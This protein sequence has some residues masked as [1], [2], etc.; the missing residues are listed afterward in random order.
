[1]VVKGFRWMRFRGGGDGREEDG[2]SFKDDDGDDDD[3]SADGSEVL[4]DGK[5]VA[6]SKDSIER[7]TRSIATLDVTSVLPRLSAIPSHGMRSGPDGSRFASQAATDA[8]FESAK[9][10]SSEGVD[11]L[12]ICSSDG[13]AHVLV[14]DMV[15]IGSCDIV[16]VP[17][18]QASH[19]NSEAHAILSQTADQELHL[20]TITL[21]LDTLGDP[22]LHVIAT[23]TKRIQNLLSYITQ[24]IHCITHDYTTGLQF[25]SR[26]IA[27]MQTELEEKQEGDLITNLYHLALTGTFSDT[28]KEWLVDI[29]KETNHKRWDQAVN[30][31][32]TNIQQHLFVH[33]KPALDRLSV[34]TTT[35]RGYARYLEESSAFEVPS[36]LFTK[37]LDGIDSLRVVSQKLLL[38]VMEEQRQFKAFSKWLRVMIDIGVAGPG[39]KGGVETEA[40]ENPNLEFPLLLKYVEHTML[41]SRLARFVEEKGA[42]HALASPE[43]SEMSYER[44]CEAVGKVDRLAENDDGLRVKDIQDAEALVNLPALTAYLS[45]N[46][47]V[48]L[49]RVTEWQSKMLAP[50]TSL[51]VPTDPETQILDMQVDVLPH[52]D[53][54]Q[55]PNAVTRLLLLPAETRQHLLLYSFF[56]DPYTPDDNATEHQPTTYHHRLEILD[57]KFHSPATILILGRLVDSEGA[58]RHLV[59]EVRVSADGTVSP[60]PSLHD[61]STHPGFVPE[62]LMV[63]G[64]EGKR[65]CLVLGNGGR[66]WVALDLESLGRDAGAAG[67]AEEEEEWMDYEEGVD[68]QM[69]G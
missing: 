22:L 32:Y 25:P 2:G 31:M 15:K 64:R 10:E 4:S 16:G 57:A 3:L 44:T 45:G 19:T 40:K 17:L 20:N 5:R 26:L 48:A 30:T 29:V 41:R 51:H 23:N 60:G 49:E 11:A 42:A 28:M 18:L 24:T 46:V 9:E 61:M 13:R 36:E 43:L 63:G 67:G 68:E 69:V 8:V 33:L 65:V 27:N 6:D 50:P 7:L 47:R 14:D 39:S 21:P 56:P 34:A 38:V 52:A 1:M 54:R 66:M 58:P 55:Q 12:V 62:R 59:S 37:I 35:L 53:G